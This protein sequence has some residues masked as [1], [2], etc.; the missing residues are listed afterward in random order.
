MTGL[1]NNGIITLLFNALQFMRLNPREIPPAP[2]MAP[3]R[4]CVVDTDIEIRVAMATQRI[5]PIN[6]AR[7]ID[8]GNLVSFS[9]PDE[10]NLTICRPNHADV[11]PPIK[12]ATAPLRIAVR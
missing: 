6:V 9:K 1:D 8:V 3:V 2:T 7:A 4:A 5:A 12:V 11:T 10:N